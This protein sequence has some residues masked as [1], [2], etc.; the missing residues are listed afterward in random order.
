[1]QQHDG[2]SRMTRRDSL[3]HTAAAFLILPAGLARG[4]AANDKLNIGVIG[5]NGGYLC[6][7]SSGVNAGRASVGE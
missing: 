4:Y 2:E 1:M 7:V 5:L 3:K 6:E